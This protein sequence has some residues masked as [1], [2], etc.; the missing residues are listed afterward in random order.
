MKIIDLLNKIANGEEVPKKIKF[1]D[2]TWV[3]K[4]KYKDFIS[5]NRCLIADYM[6]NHY[7]IMEY[8]NDEVKIIEKE[9]YKI[10]NL[11]TAINDENLG[12]EIAINRLRINQLIDVVNELINK[13]S[14]EE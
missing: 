14:E 6:V 7:G 10:N 12:S 4:K 8:L 1:E 9:K 3:Y 13:E 5:F 11:S 2:E